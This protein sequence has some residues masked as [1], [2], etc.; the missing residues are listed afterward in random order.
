MIAYLLDPG[1][2]YSFTVQA[3]DFGANWSPVSAPLVVTTP[4]A[5]LSDTSPPSV[6]T[7]LYEDHGGDGEISLHWSA[8]TDNVDPQGFIRYDVLVN[9]AVGDIAV[10]RTQSI[11]YG[12]TGTNVLS[13][14]AR[15]AAGNASAAASVTVVIP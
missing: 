9:G 7:N 5:D 2:T 13:V 8:S 11:V 12:V 3:R 10:G 15:D 14:V 1:A 4:P 6:P